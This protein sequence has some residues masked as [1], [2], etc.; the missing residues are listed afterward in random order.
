MLEVKISRGFGDTAVLLVEQLN[1]LGCETAAHY[2][3]KDFNSPHHIT[4]RVCWGTYGS[5]ELPELNHKAATFSKLDELRTFH[6]RGIPAPDWWN[7]QPTDES[8]Y[9]ILGR[10]ISHSEGKG[11]QLIETPSTIK[12]ADFYTKVI[13]SSEEFRIWIFRDKCL[14]V[15]HREICWPIQKSGFGRNWWN[16]WGYVRWYNDEISSG[17]IDYAKQAVA[18]VGLD[19]AGVDVLQGINGRWYVLETNTA[20]GATG[21]CQYALR[22]WAQQVKT[23]YEGL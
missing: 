17:A 15:Y 5:G 6:R 7:E 2:T 14:G 11:I 20:P 10:Q 23:W 22:G 13:P 19:F 9:P 16:G 21:F 1:E 18:A 12:S 3:Y 8:A 4:A